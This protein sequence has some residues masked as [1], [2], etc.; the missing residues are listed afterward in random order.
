LNVPPQAAHVDSILATPS[1][2]TEPN[3]RVFLPETWLRYLSATNAC[4]ADPPPRGSVVFEPVNPACGRF[5]FG[6]R[7]AAPGETLDYEGEPAQ[8][9]CR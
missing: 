3:D 4:V 7:P 6:D 5:P 1:G 2:S 8:R 9:E